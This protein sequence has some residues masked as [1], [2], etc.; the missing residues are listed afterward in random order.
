MVTCCVKGCSNQS[1]LNKNVSYHKI[2]GQERKDVR[3]A[4]IRAIARPVLPKAVHVCSNHFTEDS[5]DESQEPKRRLL[6]GNLKHILKP[7]AVP[8][9]FLNGK[10]VNKS[11]SSDIEETIKLTK[12]KLSLFN[13]R[14]IKMQKGVFSYRST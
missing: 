9:L 10:A 2:P 4:W 11:G 7:D 12:V 3:D 8:S 5:F 13:M 1:R 6:G 14:V